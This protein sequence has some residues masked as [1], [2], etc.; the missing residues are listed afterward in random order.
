MA[1][2]AEPAV[3]LVRGA[4]EGKVAIVTGG[5]RGIGLGIAK[6]LVDAGAKVMICA[7]RVDAL[8]EAAE[9]LGPVVSWNATHGGDPEQIAASVRATVERFGQVDI[10][11]NNA[12][13][14]PYQGR[15]IDIDL[16]RYD[17]TFEVNLRGP[18]LWTQACW[19]ASMESR[20]GCVINISSI[21]TRRWG[22]RQGVYA[23][24]KAAL[25]YLTRHLA[26]ELAPGVRVNALA[27]GM[28]PTRM[29]ASVGYTPQIP[30]LGRL[31]TPADIAAAVVFLASDAASWITGQVID[32]DGGTLLSHFNQTSA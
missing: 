31:G 27:P 3:D 32:I 28:V 25:D 8:V 18:L 22:G 12:A 10:L 5:S 24:T 29:T 26:A 20:G 23:T 15:L 17:K 4:L 1:S 21:G 16:Q 14:S 19:R 13:T 6:A 9:A 7:R 11:V 30:P 2:A